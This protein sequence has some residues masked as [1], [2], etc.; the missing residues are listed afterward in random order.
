M[1]RLSSLKVMQ[2]VHLRVRSVLL[3]AP[4]LPIINTVRTY[5]TA[6]HFS[7]PE[8]QKGPRPGEVTDHPPIGKGMDPSDDAVPLKNE[9]PA[10]QVEADKDDV[11]D[12]EETAEAEEKES[13]ER[14]WVE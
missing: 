7:T 5:A 13:I 2:C 9:G 12:E 10:A 8:Y 1:S 14:G 6:K 11:G 4:A 3:P